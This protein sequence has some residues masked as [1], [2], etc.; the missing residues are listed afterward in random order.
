MDS[1]RRRPA[2]LRAYLLPKRASHPREFGPGRGTGPC[3]PQ[4][5]SWSQS[6]R[7][8][9]GRICSGPRRA[10]DVGG[11]RARGRPSIRWPPGSTRWPP[12]PIRHRRSWPP[13]PEN[14][15]SS[16]TWSSSGPPV[17][18]QLAP[19][20]RAAPRRRRQRTLASFQWLGPRS[21]R[22]RHCAAIWWRT[23]PTSV[24]RSP[25]PLPTIG[26]STHTPRSNAARLWTSASKARPLRCAGTSSPPSIRCMNGL[27][28]RRPGAR[29]VRRRPRGLE[30]LR[31]QVDTLYDK[32]KGG[33]TRSS[34]P[35]L[36]H[37]SYALASADPMRGVAGLASKGPGSQ[38][39]KRSQG[40]WP[41]VSRYESQRRASRAVAAVDAVQHLHTQ[42]VF[43]AETP[44]AS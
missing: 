39:P 1:D 37:E 23:A 12:T 4:A 21:G 44:W 20:P 27:A 3:T 34:L 11:D 22:R 5:S 15:G 30:S 8:S 41:M 25:A 42:C 13:S 26:S 2:T 31:A 16:T 33:P 24:S 17:W 40:P 38:P 7:S 36:V 10:A 32:E 35:R 6:Y 29:R 9:S 43:A 14:C 19:P 28:D 18:T